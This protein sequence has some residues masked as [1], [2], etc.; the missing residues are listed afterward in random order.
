MAAVTDTEL[1]AKAI[2]QA[3]RDQ[4]VYNATA[5]PDQAG[6]TVTLFFPWDT[7]TVILPVE[8]DKAESPTVAAPDP[9]KHDDQPLKATSKKKG[10]A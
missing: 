10:G 2:A 7:V 8:A 1:I 6:W 5:S 9:V 3:D 4:P